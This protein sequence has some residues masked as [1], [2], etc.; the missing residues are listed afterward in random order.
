VGIG[1]PTRSCA[2]KNSW[3]D[4]EKWAP[5][6]RQDHAP[7]KIPGM[8]RKSGHRFSDKIMREKKFLA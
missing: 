2:R 4:P 1:F 5:V 6:F 8:I 7:E 3:H